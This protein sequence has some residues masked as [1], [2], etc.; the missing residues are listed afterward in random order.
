MK[1]ISY[2]IGIVL[3][4]VIFG[5]VM[6]K[7]ASVGQESVS[8]AP[9]KDGIQEVV[10]SLKNYNYYPN[11]VRVKSGTPVRISLDSIV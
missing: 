6:I 7:G 9:I 4:V 8:T 5:F 2:L 3:L 11:T 1:P 10:L